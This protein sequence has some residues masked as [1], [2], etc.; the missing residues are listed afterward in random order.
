MLSDAKQT[1]VAA[2]HLKPQIFRRQ[3]FLVELPQSSFAA[4][5]CSLGLK[6]LCNNPS[7]L[8]LRHLGPPLLTTFTL[9]KKVP[10]CVFL[11]LKKSPNAKA[12]LTLAP[13]LVTEPSLQ[14]T[15]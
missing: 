1:M 13:I 7:Y 15:L 9:P 3:P 2:V 11:S 14:I 10:K 5:I 6:G 12:S 4:S 8:H